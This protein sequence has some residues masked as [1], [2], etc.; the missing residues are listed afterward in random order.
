MGRYA[1]FSEH[2]TF[3]SALVETFM[4]NYANFNDDRQF[5]SKRGKRPAGVNLG[6]RGP[7]NRFLTAVARFLHNLD[8]IKPA[9]KWG[10]QWIY[11]KI[12]ERILAGKN[13]LGEQPRIHSWNWDL[14]A[15]QGPSSPILSFLDD[16]IVKYGNQ[17]N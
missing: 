5:G 16:A 13:G 4:E 6:E 1:K 7:P 17:H 3:F 8:M 2:G 9:K 11:G 15:M 10:C 14:S 12:W